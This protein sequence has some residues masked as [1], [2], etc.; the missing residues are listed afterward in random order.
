MNQAWVGWTCSLE[1]L[2]KAGGAN[3]ATEAV[4]CF[5]FVLILFHFKGNHVAQAT[6]D[7]KGC[8][9]PG[10]LGHLEL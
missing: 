8:P 4:G 10:G 5:C 7:A 6:V 1:C 2:T 3:C 9:P